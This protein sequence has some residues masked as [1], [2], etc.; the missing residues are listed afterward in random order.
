MIDVEYSEGGGMEL[1]H[2]WFDNPEFRRTLRNALLESDPYG[3]VLDHDQFQPLAMLSFCSLFVS[4]CVE[5]R[6][7][8]ASG[9]PQYAYR[10]RHLVDL[11]LLN[12]VD[13]MVALRMRTYRPVYEIVP[14]AADA[15]RRA[16]GELST[17]RP[18]FLGEE[19]GPAMRRRISEQFEQ[20]MTTALR[21]NKPVE[22]A[23]CGV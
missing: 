4:G 1:M 13:R 3:V 8:S 17:R 11:A 12:P 18:L 5:V 16:S 19:S 2:D 10:L 15:L 7:Q 9:E 14:E 22:P 20:I 21:F 23:G 6:R